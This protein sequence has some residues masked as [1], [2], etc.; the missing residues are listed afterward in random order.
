M[1]KSQATLE[2]RSLQLTTQSRAST[3]RPLVTK[4]NMGIMGTEESN[5]KLAGALCEF[6]L[7][8]IF[9]CGVLGN[10]CK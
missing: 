9:Q 6:R 10:K 1:A 3:F 5:T 8:M 4:I 2:S 7:G